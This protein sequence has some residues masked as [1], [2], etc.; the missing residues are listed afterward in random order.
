[1]PILF[2]GKGIRRGTFSQKSAVIDIAPTLHKLLGLNAPLRY[3]G[4]I[5]T[6]ILR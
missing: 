2:C 5:L 4:R 6:E 1:V 3:D